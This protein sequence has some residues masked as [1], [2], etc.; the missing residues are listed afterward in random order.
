MNKRKT[1]YLLLFIIPVLL[2]LAAAGLFL[3]RK[4]SVPAIS[5]HESLTRIVPGP[6]AVS[7]SEDELLHVVLMG[8]GP[9][10]DGKNTDI[11]LGSILEKKG[12]VKTYNL[13]VPNSYASAY[14]ATFRTE[15][16]LDVYSLYWLSTAFTVDNYSIYDSAFEVLDP[17][18]DEM[19]GL[20]NTIAAIDFQTIDVIAIMYD[21]S[22]YLAGRKAA[23][24]ENPSDIQTYGGALNAAIQLI[25][26]VYPHIRIVLLSPAYADS[27]DQEG[28]PRNSNQYNYHKGY[29]YDYVTA[30]ADAAAANDVTFLDTY[31]LTNQK[32]SF[33][34][35]YVHLSQDG[36]EAIAD[37]LLPVLTTTD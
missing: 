23:N 4:L 35:D 16:P 1:F 10:S 18:T 3:Y 8:N 24:P 13:S 29:L 11:S 25:K 28:N 34:T 6:A 26:T 17:V 31:Y 22:D 12:A 20:L 36:M 27:P 37:I 30:A 33:L 32:S 14:N 2:L 7:D 21:A 9:F 5:P 15:Y 19:T